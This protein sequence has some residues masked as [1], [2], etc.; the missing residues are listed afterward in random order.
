[1]KKV[2]VDSAYWIARINHQDQWHQAA[3]DARSQLSEDTIFITTEEVLTEVLTGL[4]R[5]GSQGRQ[6]AVKSV[7]AIQADPNIHIFPQ[8]R[9]SFARGLKFY[10]SRYDKGYSLQDCISMTTM[11]STGVTEVLTIDHHVEQEGYVILMSK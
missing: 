8:T 11:E 1:M 2:F 10:K 6:L 5:F 7:E 3:L 4:A 9:D